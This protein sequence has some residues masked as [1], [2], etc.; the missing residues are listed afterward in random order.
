MDGR[1]RAGL[2]S[3]GG[4]SWSVTSN[5]S[6]SSKAASK[7]LS[8]SDS[9]P[10]S[11]PPSSSIN[12]FKVRRRVARSFEVAGRVDE[13]VEGSEEGLRSDGTESSAAS[14]V[15]NEA[16]GAPSTWLRMRVS[17]GW[18]LTPRMSPGLAS[19]QSD[20][21]VRQV[22]GN[23][24]AER[25]RMTHECSDAHIDQAGPRHFG[26]RQDNIRGRFRC[27]RGRYRMDI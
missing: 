24:P 12:S 21:A 23:S 4:R 6:G 17:E 9:Y 15:E 11:S 2:S 25:R 10:S 13:V 8:T 18:G 26:R 16:R 22:S 27:R 3:P 20:S 14:G 1:G 7:S 19:V 5:R